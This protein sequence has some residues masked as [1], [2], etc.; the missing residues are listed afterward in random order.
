MTRRRALLARVES[1]GGRLP[2]EYQEV[3]YLGAT[4][5]QYINTGFVMGLVETL[6]AT[7][8]FYADSAYRNSDNPIVWLRRYDSTIS[9]DNQVDYKF[10]NVYQGNI[11]V[12]GYGISNNNVATVSYNTKIRM[13]FDYSPNNQKIYKDGTLV[14]TNSN[15]KPTTPVT[16][17]LWLLRTNSVGDFYFHGRLYYFSIEVNGVLRE[18][19]PCYRKADGV[20]GLYEIHFKQFFINAGTGVFLAGPDI[21]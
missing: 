2:A 9:N 14:F 15:A 6:K 5:T 12:R 21:I 7:S 8:V 10:P 20:R 19:I 11:E 13:D 17:E 4:G 1:G 18:Y 3:E 16:K